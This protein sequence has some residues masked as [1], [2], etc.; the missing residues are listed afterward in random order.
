MTTEFLQKCTGF[1]NIDLIIK[2]LPSLTQNTVTIRDTGN[3]PVLSRGEIATL[4]K[5]SKNS[6]RVPCPQHVGD[7]FHY[8]IGYGD[9]HAIG[10]IYYVLFLLCRKTRNKYVFD[11]KNLEHDTI[12]QQMKKF[13]RIIGKYPLV[14]IADHNFPFIRKAIDNF[15]DPRM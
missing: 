10:G 9:G 8:D 12:L 6:S 3:D 11:L 4:P 13:I 5:K 7:I 1:H 2:N 14:M 15:L